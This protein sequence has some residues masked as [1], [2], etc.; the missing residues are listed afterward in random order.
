MFLNHP[1]GCE[2]CGQVT[3]CAFVKI[4]PNPLEIIILPSVAIKGGSPITDTIKPLQRPKNVPIK[5][6]IIR[7]ITI[8]T[9]DLVVITSYSIHYTKL[10]DIIS[11][12]SRSSLFRTFWLF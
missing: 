6:P 2:D 12:S 9:L 7:Q 8:G 1:P 5:T 11:N 3:L 4:E 10:Y